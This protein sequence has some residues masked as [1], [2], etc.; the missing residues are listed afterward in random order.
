MTMHRF[1]KLT[2][3][4]ARQTQRFAQDESGATAIEYAMVA[5]AIGAA[6]TGAVAVLGISTKG[7]YESVVTLVK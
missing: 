1:T 7:M 3:F 5:S 4:I 2:S 6:I